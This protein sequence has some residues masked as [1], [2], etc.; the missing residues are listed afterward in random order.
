MLLRIRKPFYMRRRY[1]APDNEAWV[2]IKYAD[3]KNYE[4]DQDIKRRFN[5][6]GYEVLIFTVFDHKIGP[7]LFL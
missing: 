3:P 1:Y 5:S 7:E 4:N 6:E 2:F